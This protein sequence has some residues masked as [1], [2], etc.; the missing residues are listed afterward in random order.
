[1]LNT[2]TMDDFEQV[3]KVN[4]L[5]KACTAF[6]QSMKVQEWTA[7][8]ENYQP[9]PSNARL[10]SLLE[11]TENSALVLECSIRPLPFGG[12]QKS[13]DQKNFA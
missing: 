5:K 6:T 8:W 12:K 10:T 7:L 4:A 3:M 9:R 1:M 2:I 13:I 11:M